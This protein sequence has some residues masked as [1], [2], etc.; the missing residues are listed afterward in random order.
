MA[1][2]RREF[3]EAVTTDKNNIKSDLIMRF[4]SLAREEQEAVMRRLQ[5][6]NETAYEP[7]HPQEP[8]Q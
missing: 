8:G 5:W 7:R 1:S 3:D 2:R 6:S 4:Y